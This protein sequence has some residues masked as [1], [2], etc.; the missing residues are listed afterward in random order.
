ME[1]VTKE[2]TWKTVVREDQKWDKNTEGLWLYKAIKIFELV[3]PCAINVTSWHWRLQ[4]IR[5]ILWKTLCIV[6]KWLKRFPIS[7]ASLLSQTRCACGSTVAIVLSCV[8]T[9]QPT[10]NKTTPRKSSGNQRKC[11]VQNHGLFCRRRSEQAQ[12]IDTTTSVI[13]IITPDCAAPLCTRLTKKIRRTHWPGKR[14]STRVTG[15]RHRWPRQPGCQSLKLM[16][17]P[18]MTLDNEDRRNQSRRRGSRRLW[19]DSDSTWIYYV[20]KITLQ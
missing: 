3:F 20:T 18:V 11:C 4:W 13:L 14:R 8:L 9:H 7:A 12:P 17:M 19:D 10:P 16:T 5:R 6:R 1:C 15:W 2:K